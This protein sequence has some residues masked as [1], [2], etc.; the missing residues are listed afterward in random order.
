PQQLSEA[1]PA[2]QLTHLVL[3]ASL[4]RI[5]NYD[6]AVTEYLK[7]IPEWARR[8]E[9]IASLREAYAEFGMQGFWR[10]Y[11]EYC[12]EL[13]RHRII[14]P[15]FIASLHTS[16]EQYDEAFEWIEKAF[17]EHDSALSHIK[18]D[19]RLQKLHSDPRFS[20]LL[21]RMGLAKGMGLSS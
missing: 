3:G 11:A 16:L 13:Y 1:E 6:E 19:P 2:Y 15:L 5:E 7:M 9:M 18:A 20:E 17:R 8:D 12:D 4:E 14:K 10:R 21:D